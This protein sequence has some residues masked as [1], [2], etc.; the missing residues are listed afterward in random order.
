MNASA[1]SNAIDVIAH[2]QRDNFS[3]VAP[4]L[5]RSSS[6]ARISILDKPTIDGG[7]GNDKILI[8]DGGTAL[9]D[10]DFAS[11][12]SVE[13]LALNAPITIELKTA[14]AAAGITTVDATA[15]TAGQAVAMQGSAT[16]TVL[17]NAGNLSASQYTGNLKVTATGSG[18]NTITT[19]SGND[20]ITGGA[21]GDTLTGGAG[22]DTFVFKAI[23]DSQPGAGHFD[24]ITDF[25]HNSDHF[26]F[27][28]I[29][30]LNSNNQSIS[31]NSLISTPTT[32]APHTIDIVTSGG[33][34]IVYAN[35]SGSTQN[36]ASADMEIHL[37]S[38][39]TLSQNDFILHA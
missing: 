36:I 3:P 33:N 15:L 23:T 8:T 28:A 39:T 21:G 24:T 27:S 19:G 25:T 13:T 2:G 34:T 14:A 29:S 38:I 26:D 1:T 10:G 5:T 32:I 4:A 11:I 20:T 7:L 17:L 12:H 30:G 16:E 6:K 22:N 9:G 31:F 37:T 35:A 18:A